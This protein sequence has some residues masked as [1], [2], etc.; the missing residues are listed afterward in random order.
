MKSENEA[1]QFKKKKDEKKTD[2]E[3]LEKG[4]EFDV[5]GKGTSISGDDGTAGTASNNPPPGDNETGKDK[6][7]EEHHHGKRYTRKAH[8]ALLDSYVEFAK[9]Y[10]NSAEPLA[11]KI[12]LSTAKK[13]WDYFSKHLVTEGVGNRMGDE[14]Q[15]YTF[16]EFLVHAKVE[17]GIVSIAAVGQDKRS[18][19]KQMAVG[20]RQIADG[21]EQMAEG[22]EKAVGGSEQ[23]AE[24]SKQMAVGSKKKVVDSK[25]LAEA[26]EQ[27]AVG[28]GEKAAGE[29]EQKNKEQKQAP[30]V[31]A[32]IIPAEKKSV[33]NTPLQNTTTKTGDKTP[34]KPAPVKSETKTV[35]EEQ[36]NIIYEKVPPEKFNTTGYKFSSKNGKVLSSGEVYKFIQ[37]E[38]K[39]GN[40]EFIAAFKAHIKGKDAEG[41]SPTFEIAG[42]KIKYFGYSFD[43]EFGKKKEVK[44]EEDTFLGR[45]E[46]TPAIVR[47]KH[48]GEDIS[49][50]RLHTTPS[51]YDEDY[52]KKK[53]DAL[54]I[55]KPGSKL[56]ILNN[57]NGKNP[58]WVYVQTIDG[59]KGW[60]EE[61][62]LVKLDKGDENEYT[63]HVVK[64]GE[65]IE[66][67]LGDIEGLQRDIGYDNR[68]FAYVMLQMNR[69]NGGVHINIDRFEASMKENVGKNAS[70]P[71]YMG[72]RAVYQSIQIKE[73]AVVKVPTK[74]GIDNMIAKG[75][76]PTRPELMNAAIKGGRIAEGL[77]KGIP[78]GIYEQGKDM[79]TGLWDMIK[80]IFTGEI[81]EQ[82]EQLYH[83]LS[84]MTWDDAKTFLASMI[85][86]DLKKFEKL[87][88]GGNVKV[89]TRYEYIGE[90]I[91]RLTFEIVLSVLTGG[92]KAA[93]LVSRIPA[94][95]KIVNA[96]RKV[97]KLLPDEVV[98]KLK[99]SE[100]AVGKLEEGKTVKKVEK[101]EDVASHK[102]K[103]AK[104]LEEGVDGTKK[105]ELE[106]EADKEV[107]SNEKDHDSKVAALA[108]AKV[109]TEGA[110]KVDMP[111]PALLAELSF[112]KRFKGVINFVSNKISTGIYKIVMIGSEY[113][114]DGNYTPGKD[115]K[116]DFPNGQYQDADYHHSQSSGRKNKAPKNGQKALDNS[117]SIGPDTERRVGVADGEIVI[118]DKTT[119]EIFHG[120]VRTWDE[121]LQE[122]SKSQKIRNTLL[123]NGLVNQ[124]GKILI[125]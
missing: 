17:D 39:K 56:N 81:L 69:G 2:T 94:A 24:G 102:S 84:N 121:L 107:K 54:A 48:K 7:E 45:V 36:G 125:N 75:L 116:K 32:E 79:V 3:T 42:S 41:T 16:E 58:G 33:Q 66:K 20:S 123:K 30:I 61:H 49:G 78:T 62:Y 15:A 92:A 47:Y 114:V 65:T 59:K 64:E 118:L 72:I 8:E 96:L 120:H 35:N 86:I 27:V 76:V 85:G 100:K 87:W 60:I 105:K 104:E 80:S 14:I 115:N 9:D 91:G 111:I 73:G 34:L 117:H 112:L 10:Y 26:R 28:D 124:K 13:Y 106:K 93:T 11:L 108:I 4:E 53:G 95:A 23:M 12:E 29:L 46:N 37:E 22:S 57:A 21:S 67:I 70:D 52:Q 77:L 6:T 101:I 71:S 44:K 5:P 90:I 63:L 68:A 99:K 83:A 43:P 55:Y 97:D 51:P 18:G 88:S 122:G 1:L 82:L 89:E 38:K 98:K 110:D 31:S 109:I 25:Q 113:T 119:D 40:E 50:I 103:K 74:K 19:A